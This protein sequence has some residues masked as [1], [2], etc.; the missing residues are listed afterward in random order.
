MP[1][2]SLSVYLTCSECGKVCA[3]TTTVWYDGQDTRRDNAAQANRN[4]VKM[5]EDPSFLDTA[6]ECCKGSTWVI[7]E[8]KVL[9]V[10]PSFD[11]G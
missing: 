1:D 5:T 8:E 11:E 3:A 10:K 7:G 4:L 6:P 9:S 2:M